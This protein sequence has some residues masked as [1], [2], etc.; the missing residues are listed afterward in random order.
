MMI[1]IFLLNQ[2]S[3]NCNTIPANLGQFLRAPSRRAS[4]Q[5]REATYQLPGIMNNMH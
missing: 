5:G 2:G 4:T 1:I 3:T